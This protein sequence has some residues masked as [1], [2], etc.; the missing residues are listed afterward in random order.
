MSEPA[1][2]FDPRPGANPNNVWWKANA[3]EA[4]IFWWGYELLWGASGLDSEF[5]QCSG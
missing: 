4:G 1:L 3:G 2:Q 5:V